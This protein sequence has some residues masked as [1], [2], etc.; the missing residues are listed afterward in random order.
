MIF[1]PISRKV[2]SATPVLPVR[3][4]HVHVMGVAYKRNIDDVRE[5][6]ALDIIH[7]LRQRGAE[8]TY[9]DPYVPSLRIEGRNIDAIDPCR[10]VLAGCDLAMIIT[11]HTAFDYSEIIRNAPLV[12]DTRNA[13]DGARARNLVRL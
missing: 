7:L 12:F 6:P 2:A 1:A 4:S 11:N 3:G 10:E 9:S 5:S 13:T 8:V